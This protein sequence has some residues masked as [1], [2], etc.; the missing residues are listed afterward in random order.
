MCIRDRF[1]TAPAEAQKRI[2]AERTDI[3]KRGKKYTV[4]YTSVS[5]PG[6]ANK[7]TGFVGLPPAMRTPHPHNAG[8]PPAQLSCLE[9][10]AQ[11][12]S[13]LSLIHI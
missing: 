3:Q 6:V 5:G 12:T 8:T 11:P 9:E 4:G 13:S 1:K 2:L 7:I 10:S